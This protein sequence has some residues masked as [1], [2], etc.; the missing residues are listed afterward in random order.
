M[1]QNASAYTFTTF[2]VPEA[3]DAGTVGTAIN[4]AGEVA[5]FWF[6][7]NNGYNEEPFLTYNGTIT[8]FEVPG[9]TYGLAYWGPWISNAGEVVGSYFPSDGTVQ[10]FIENHGSVSQLAVPGAIDTIPLAMSSSGEVLGTWDNNSNQYYFVEKNG[11]FTNVSLPAGDSPYAINDAGTIA[12][13]NGS[14]RF[15]K[16]PLQVF[17]DHAGKIT[18]FDPAPAPQQATLEALYM[19]DSDEVVGWYY[20]NITGSHSFLYDKGTVTSLPGYVTGINNAGQVIGQYYPN[21]HEMGFVYSDGTFTSIAPPGA[22]WT[23]PTG[24][25]NSGE[26]T[27]TWIDSNDNENGFV[28]TP[29]G[30]VTSTDL[31]TASGLA[32]ER[33]DNS[34]GVPLSQLFGSVPAADLLPPSRTTASSPW[35]AQLHSA[36]ATALGALTYPD[37]STVV[38]PNLHGD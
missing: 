13:S 28:G 17:I 7:P 24:I 37:V 31:S 18:T 20:S 14:N 12:G 19:N 32:G 26:I 29:T 30:A 3:A 16:N 22:T 5:G 8:T 38:M 27:G 11:S 1:V 2:D 10:G 35:A 15:G 33:S 34:S 9:A 36:S 25:N 23:T 21:G 4:S 6:D